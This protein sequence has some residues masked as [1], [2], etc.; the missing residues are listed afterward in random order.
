MIM[1]PM[2]IP[3]INTISI[4]GVVANLAIPCYLIFPMI[5]GELSFKSI[6]EKFFTNNVTIK[7]DTTL[8]ETIDFERD[9]IQQ[10]FNLKPIVRFIIIS[11]RFFLTFDLIQLYLWNFFTGS[12]I[13]KHLIMVDRIV[14]I[15]SKDINSIREPILIILGFS[16]AELTAVLIGVPIFNPN[17]LN[18]FLHLITGN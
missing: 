15:K 2:V 18:T 10:I 1:E 8:K 5:A 13:I 9:Y 16:L 7:Y 11:V 3:K 17:D 6:R 4:I 12:K 14:P